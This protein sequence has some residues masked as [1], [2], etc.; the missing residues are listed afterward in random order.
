V[1]TNF[2]VQAT[3]KDGPSI[4][5][6]VQPLYAPTLSNPPK[7]LLGLSNYLME[8]VT[9]RSKREPRMSPLHSNISKAE[10]SKNSFPDNIQQLDSD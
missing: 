7:F 6:N 10:L 8:E 3:E 5:E 4:Q 2:L 9:Q 1:T